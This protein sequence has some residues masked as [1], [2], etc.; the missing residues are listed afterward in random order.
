MNYVLQQ[1]RKKTSASARQAVS[2]GAGE[3]SEACATIQASEAGQTETKS[4]VH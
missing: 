3:N 4:T 1:R 2:E